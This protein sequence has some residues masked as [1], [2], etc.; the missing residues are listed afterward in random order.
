L[1]RNVP[2]KHAHY[3]PAA[4]IHSRSASELLLTQKTKLPRLTTVCSGQPDTVSNDVSGF[5]AG[6]LFRSPFRCAW[7]PTIISLRHSCSQTRATPSD[8][9]ACPYG[10]FPLPGTCDSGWPPTVLAVTNRKKFLPAQPFLLLLRTHN[11]ELQRSW[12]S[13]DYAS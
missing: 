12:P 11:S 2:R 4:Y 10:T 8:N 7:L 6:N 5:N 13:H 3:A 1:C 9:A